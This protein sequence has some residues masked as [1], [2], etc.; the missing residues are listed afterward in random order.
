MVQQTNS[1]FSPQGIR[2]RCDIS[3]TE[4]TAPSYLTVKVLSTTLI[5][6]KYKYNREHFQVFQQIFQSWRNA[7]RNTEAVNCC[8]SQNYLIEKGDIVTILFLSISYTSA[9]SLVH[10]I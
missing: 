6:F 1:T 2:E 9:D 4:P 3:A 7:P 8:V 10:L 5:F